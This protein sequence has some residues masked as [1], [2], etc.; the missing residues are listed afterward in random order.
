MNMRKVYREV[1]KQNGVSVQEVKRE[2]QAAITE[3]YNARESGETAKAWKDLQCRG[4]VPTPEELIG[5][6]LRE[7]LKQEINDNSQA[8]GLCR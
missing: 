5:F 3:A 7:V 6:V 8:E 2:M 4:E 1:A